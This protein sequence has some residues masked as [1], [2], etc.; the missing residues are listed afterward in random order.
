MDY[1]LV[2]VGPGHWPAVFAALLLPV[3]AVP[4]WGWV[5]RRADS[6]VGWASDL[7]GGW[8]RTDLGSRCAVWLML[9]SGVIHCAL[10]LG[11]Q[12]EAV[13]TVLFL[14]TGLAYGWFAWRAVLGRPWRIATTV[15]LLATLA[16]YLVVLG[17]HL[18]ES[19]QVGLVTAL[20]EMVALGLVAVPP[21]RG[22]E[23][24][25]RRLL[26]PLVNVG[27]VVLIIG[28]GIYTWEMFF[29]E[30]H[31]TVRS[32]GDT[33]VA[34]GHH[35]GE[36][37]GRAQAGTVQLP[38]GPPPTAEEIRTADDVARRI[39]AFAARYADPRQAI[40]DGYVLNDDVSV[41]LQTHYEKKEHVTDGRVADPE[42]PE[43]LVYAIVDGR[44][45]LLGVLF[46]GSRA[47]S[48]GPRFAGNIARWHAHNVCVTALPQGSGL[49][50][51]LG[52]CPP[53]S[54]M[55]TTVDMLHVWVVDPPGGPYVEHLDQ[56]WIRDLVAR[57]GIAMQ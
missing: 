19:D 6:G 14:G 22:F 4:V 32:G 18:E 9:I 44:A 35:H 3:V 46:Q 36:S 8:A 55:V 52:G 17:Q 21:V 7:V 26:R 27:V 13:F 39:K 49:V 33:H 56:E 40:A 37:L 23:G 10:L 54:L 57:E 24:T 29:E 15:L 51:P 31:E 47:G 2:G 28:V 5:R 41:D 30:H 1:V 48:R 45:K 20:L 25:R 50:S 43:M 34:G 42:A 16:A 12:H 38:P 53:L 11:H